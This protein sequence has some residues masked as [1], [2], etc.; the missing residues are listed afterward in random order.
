MP[1]TQTRLATDELPQVK[2][3]AVGKLFL[4]HMNPRLA[5][6]HLTLDDQDKILEVLWRERAV[7]ELVD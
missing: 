2:P 4:D 5:G 7:N 6:E 3:V 1:A